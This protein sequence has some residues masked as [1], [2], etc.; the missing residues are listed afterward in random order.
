[1]LHRSDAAHRRARSATATMHLDIRHKLFLAFALTGGLVVAVLVLWHHW[2]FESGFLHYV[3]E[4]EATRLEAL[5][6]DLEQLYAEKRN[7][8]FVDGRDR[9]LAHG[10]LRAGAD[11]ASRP[12]PGSEHRSP[13]GQ[14][15]HPR[16]RAASFGL[17]ERLSLRDADGRLLAGAPQQ[18]AHSARRDIHYAGGRVGYLE[19]APIEALSEAIDLQFASQQRGTLY[20]TAFAILVAA[21]IAAALL[22]RNLATPVRELARGTH[23]LASGRYDTRIRLDR[24]DELGRLAGDFNAL[25]QALERNRKARKALVADIS[26]ELRTPIAILRAELEGLEDGVRTLDAQA[27]RSL[28]AEVARLGSLVDDLYELARSDAGALSYSKQAVALPRLLEDVVASFRERLAAA[29]LAV[30]IDCAGDA[31][32]HADPDRLRQLFANVLENSLRYTDTGG[33]VRISQHRHG[34]QVRVT[35]EDS[36]PGVPEAALPRLFDRLYR[37]DPSRSRETGAAGLGLA[38]CASIVE[39]HGGAIGARHSPLGGIAIDV[40]LPLHERA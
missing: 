1:M 28:S 9:W 10:F 32:V 22:A 20:V 18:R 27:V 26:H 39:A 38:I 35:I 2:S 6:D 4:A 25:A 13:R 31:T 24:S 29:G 23:A 36:A 14:P 34:P 16:H 15:P 11:P 8:D 30:Q 19:L 40:D 33:N 21:A 17:G 7:W 12:P 37:V 5:R 3:N